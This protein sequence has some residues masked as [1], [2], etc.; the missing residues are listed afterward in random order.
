MVALACASLAAC[1]A[2]PEP[3]LPPPLPASV[4]SARADAPVYQIGQAWSFSFVNELDAGKSGGYS[5][6]VER[7]EK[8]HAIVS[9]I[10]K[11]SPGVGELDEN[12]CVVRG[13]EALFTPSNQALRFPLFVGKSWAADYLYS[14]GAWT[15]KDHR[16]A[17]V[18]S[19]ERV[20]TEAGVF[21]AF[22]VESTIAWTGVA[23][24]SDAGRARET[25]WYAPSV[26]RIVKQRFNDYPNNKNA[27]P[28]ST[29][30]EL[31]RYAPTRA[32]D[33]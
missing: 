3:V 2:N 30:Y 14:S 24:G 6:R 21:D 5:Q 17:K 13:P 16:E 15:A 31:V 20:A 27:A 9:V 8:G 10:V 26:G 19:F 1:A 18:V 28:T 33:K 7:V 12:A 23:A 32:N 4:P 11:G 25:D 22:R 29:R